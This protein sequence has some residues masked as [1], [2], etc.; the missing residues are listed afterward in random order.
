MTMSMPVWPMWPAQTSQPLAPLVQAPVLQLVFDDTLTS[1]DVDATGHTASA[2]MMASLRRQ[3]W[4][5][6]GS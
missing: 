1:R 2:I 6:V 4:Q 3:N 5:L